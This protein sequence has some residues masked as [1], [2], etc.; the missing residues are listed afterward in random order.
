[1][2]QSRVALFRSRFIKTVSTAISIALMI[3]VGQA[4][5]ANAAA[6]TY[7]GIAY[8]YVTGATPQLSV[9]NGVYEYSTS[10]VNSRTTTD[11][12]VF[13]TAGETATVSWSGNSTSGSSDIPTNGAD[14]TKVVSAIPLSYGVNTVIITPTSQSG[15]RG[16]TYTVTITRTLATDSVIAAIIFPGIALGYNKDVTS[17]SLSVPN[18]V[19]TTTVKATWYGL[20]QTSTFNINGGSYTPLVNESASSSFN[21]DVGTNTINVVG[22]AQDG[23]TTTT[24]VISITRAAARIS[25]AAIGGVTAPVTGATPVS[26][27]TAANGYTGT[28]SWSGSPTT[29]APDTAYTA[30]ITLTAASG[31]TLSGVSANFFTVAGATSVT[32]SANSGVIT[33]VFGSTGHRVT[34]SYVLNAPNATV[35]TSGKTIW[36]VGV[37][38]SLTPPTPTLT[39]GSGRVVTFKGWKDSVTGSVTSP[40]SNWSPSGTE[41]SISQTVTMTGQWGFDV[42]YSYRFYDAVTSTDTTINATSGG[43]WPTAPNPQRAGYTL[44]GWKTQSGTPVVRGGFPFRWLANQNGADYLVADWKPNIYQMVFNQDNG[45]TYVSGSRVQIATTDV[46]SVIPPTMSKVGYALDGW[47]DP[48]NVKV[49]SSYAGDNKCNMYYFSPCPVMLHAVWTPKT[50]T[51]TFDKNTGTGTAPGNL[52]YTSGTSL[53]LPSN[54]FTPP[55]GQTFVGWSLSTNGSLISSY[56]TPTN[57]TSVTIYAIWSGVSQY[58]ITFNSMGGSLVNPIVASSRPISLP[59]P[60]LTGY[61]FAGWFPTTSGGARAGVASESYASYT[62]TMSSTLYAHW[63]AMVYVLIFRNVGTVLGTTAS[64]GGFPSNNYYV[65]GNG[66]ITLPVSP[67]PILS[68]KTFLGWSLSPYQTS[69]GS[70]VSKFGQTTVIGNG[71]NGSNVNLYP[72]WG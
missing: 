6:P 51:I 20:G 49:A 45:G 22:K 1:M 50:T 46:S 26:T 25:V 37:T 56:N 63:N 57:S 58:T 29:F 44:I 43:T 18:S 4:P 11:L 55:A 28:V 71:I 41:S 24:Y 64:G 9:S 61:S 3:S 33:A 48:S 7:N 35:D 34:L 38:T 72:I 39:N 40:G 68:G 66:D 13:L 8:M 17:Y 15:A 31:Y 47:Y 10:V 69:A 19:S 36:N 12:G 67:I 23:T 27:V 62:P 60:T 32:H 53:P 21:L 30:I 5:G 42:S 59:V 2:F 54:T 16:R 65:F 70:K 52:S 14:S